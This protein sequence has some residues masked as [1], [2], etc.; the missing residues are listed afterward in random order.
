MPRSYRTTTDALPPFM[1][2]GRV[3]VVRRIAGQPA[4]ARGRA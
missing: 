2:R 3:V 1:G 4:A